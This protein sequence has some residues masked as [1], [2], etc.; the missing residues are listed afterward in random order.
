MFDFH[1]RV[2]QADYEGYYYTRWDKERATP[3]VIRAATRDEAFEQAF[4]LMGE[5]RRGWYW[6]AKID[7]I[8]SVVSA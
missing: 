4:A 2:T 7:R 6:T 3:L 1:M 8:E 5:C